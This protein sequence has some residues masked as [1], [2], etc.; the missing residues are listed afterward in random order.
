M[1]L[2]K[3]TSS[4]AFKSNIKKEIEAGKSQ[5]Q[6]VAIAYSEQREA[7]KDETESARKYDGNGWYEIVGNPISK[8]GV[9]PYSGA[10]IG[11]PN[12][13][14]IYNVYRP[15]DELSSEETLKSF[16]LLPFINDH[17]M[18]GAGAEGLTPAEQKGVEGVIGDNVYYDNGI[19]YGNIKVFSENL[20][21]LI[22]AGKKE[23]SAGYRCI[24]EMVS[25]VWNGIKYDAI[26]RNIRG[27]HL[28]LVDQGRM[29][30]D[31]AVLDHF[32]ITF[33]AKD[34][35]MSEEEKKKDERL[36]K[37]LDWAEKRMAKDA[38]EEEE[39]KKAEDE[40]YDDD[41]KDKKAEDEDM[42]DKDKKDAKDS[43]INRVEKLESIER[44]GAALDS[45]EKQFADFK[46]NSTKTLLADI[47]AKNALAEKLS[48]HIGTFDHADKTLDEVAKY[49]V[50][51]L[52]IPCTAGNEHAVLT[53][54]LHN[55]TVSSVGYAADSAPKKSGKLAETLKNINKAAKKE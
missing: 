21:D 46:A 29:G 13:N 7:A 39:K 2:E 33:D 32:K 17:V 34:L 53:G 55:R 31:V 4:S 15:E 51:K 19:L 12:P 20:A 1:P 24:Y 27:N 18:L 5:K 10:A 11:A 38:A 37:V 49:G 3:S 43:D 14:E 48:H 30:K 41:D 52:A 28:A 47:A 45:L 54:F 26:Q 22:E 9:F 25:G 40:K 42:D 35:K 16:R 8:V 6:A 50:E 23:L 36:E 44:T